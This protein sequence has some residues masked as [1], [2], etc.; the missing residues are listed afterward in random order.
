[1]NERI[2]DNYIKRWGANYEDDRI[3]YFVD[4]YNEFIS[5][6]SPE[7]KNY[8][9]CLMEYFVYY[10]HDIVNREYVNLYN[11]LLS[12]Y[13]INLNC[14]IFTALESKT[15][16][17]NSSY[18]CLNQFRLVNKIS[19]KNF[20]ALLDD[21]YK[22]KDWWNNIE[23]IVF[24]DDIC[25]SGDTF[26]TFFEQNDIE[27]R[28]L[29]IK[30]KNIYYVT[31]H[32]M[33]QAKENIVKYANDNGIILMPVYANIADTAFSLDSYLVGIKKKFIEEAKTLGF[34]KEEEIL[35]W[36]YAEALVSFYEDSPNN[37][38]GIFIKDRKYNKSIFPR[39]KGG[40]IPGFMLSTKRQ[41]RNER[42]Y[43]NGSGGKNN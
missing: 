21:I 39:E 13:E 5:N 30:E 16:Q 36:K 14:T 33:E 26:I 10:P 15:G 17:L 1:M 41:Q 3:K 24:V 29:D 31:V 42:N 4:N 40:D 27:K 28:I 19:K 12:N 38:L 18:G 37:T 35:G 20:Y 2:I 9:N 6:F 22:E 25:G 11:K 8:V 7:M 34:K 43:A 23:N 32:M